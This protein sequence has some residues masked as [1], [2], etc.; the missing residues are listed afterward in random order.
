MRVLSYYLGI[1]ALWATACVPWR[2][3]EGRVEMTGRVVANV[4][5]V[6][7]TLR[8][9]RVIR[10]GGTRPIY[11]S[12]GS[13]DV[14]FSVRYSAGA[15]ACTNDGVHT[16]GQIQAR[17]D[18]GGTLERPVAFPLRW[19]SRCGPGRYTV[20]ASQFYSWDLQNRRGR[21]VRLADLQL[22][23]LP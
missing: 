16:L 19:L 7:D 4:L 1:A 14:S 9:Q 3:G 15:L 20:D 5:R 8:I 12:W 6:S 13:T 2:S 17:I 21:E 22:T 18:P 10:N 11:V 23:I